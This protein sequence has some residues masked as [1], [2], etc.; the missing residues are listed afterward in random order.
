MKS[1]VV[2][3]LT[4][5][6][7]A[8]ILI[9]GFTWGSQE[10]VAM[11]SEAQNDAPWLQEEPEPQYLHEHCCEC[12]AM[13]GV[14][15]P[16]EMPDSKV[17]ESDR[18]EYEVS[19]DTMVDELVVLW[20]LM[21]DDDGAKK[22]DP[23]REKFDRYAEIV[24][25]WVVYYQNNETDIGG[26]LPGHMNDHLLAGIIVK[27]ESSVRPEVVGAAPRFEVGMMQ[28]WGVALAGYSRE[29]VKN[30]T[31][32]GVMLGVRWLASRV[33]WCE[34]DELEENGW[35]DSSWVGPLSLYASGPPAQKSKKEKTCRR[36]KPGVERSRALSL[37]RARVDA[38]MLMYGD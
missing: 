22:A 5:V 4:A 26:K 10:E 23:R 11:A 25:D 24:A 31:K 9:V 8:L 35:D 30:N 3:V 12:D 29:Q 15:Y 21:F 19:Y 1:E 18:A 14:E 6:L 37:Y 16:V 32:L 38:E 13:A 34:G 2:S 17:D 28:V 33:Q 27:K 20:N 36:F 7:V